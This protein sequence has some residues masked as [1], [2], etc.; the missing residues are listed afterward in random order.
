MINLTAQSIP[1]A[2]ALAK[3]MPDGTEIIVKD[4]KKSPM[5]LSINR[6]KYNVINELVYGGQTLVILGNGTPADDGGRD[7]PS[8]PASVDYREAWLGDYNLTEFLSGD[9]WLEIEAILRG[10]K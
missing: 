8:S 1:E 3:F 7:Y 2:E 9:Q 6:H 5:Q 10:E 4:A